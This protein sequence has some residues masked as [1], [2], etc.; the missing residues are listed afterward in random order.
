MLL[1]A[2]LLSPVPVASAEVGLGVAVCGARGAVT[3]DAAEP[4]LALDLRVHWHPRRWLGLGLT[5]L[6]AGLPARR[7]ETGNL[8]FVGPEVA[9]RAAPTSTLGLIAAGSL[10]WDRV[11]GT[12]GR[13]T[14]LGAVGLRLGARSRVGRRL[15]LGVD[16]GLLRPVLDEA[17]A[18]STCGPVDVALLHR[19]SLVVGVPFW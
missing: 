11:A 13:Q 16:Y 19:F 17:C 12:G 8:T 10:G 18:G 7:T 4:G 14:G 5:G 15:E 2:A 6:Y 3:C 1:V 9:L